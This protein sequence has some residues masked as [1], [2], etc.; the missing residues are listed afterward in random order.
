MLVAFCVCGINAC[1][2]NI[3]SDFSCSRV[4]FVIR[5]IASELVKAAE[6]KAVTQ[7]TDFKFN[8]GVGLFSINN[9]RASRVILKPN[10][11]RFHAPMQLRK[12]NHGRCL[13]EESCGGRD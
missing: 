4:F 7:M 9:I 3:D 11:W 5:E 12:E 8:K 13:N 2:I 1:R 6:D 10:L